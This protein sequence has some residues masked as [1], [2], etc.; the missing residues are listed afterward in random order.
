MQFLM[1]NFMFY[2][3]REPVGKTAKIHKSNSLNIPGINK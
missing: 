1:W 2:L 3:Q